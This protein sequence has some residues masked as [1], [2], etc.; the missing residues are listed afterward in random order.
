MTFHRSGDPLPSRRVHE[1]HAHVA[2]AEFGERPNPSR[3]H[4][5]PVGGAGG[6]RHV[7]H[8]EA[9]RGVV[10]VEGQLVVGAQ[11]GVEIGE[12]GHVELRQLGGRRLVDPRPPEAPALGHRVVDEHDLAVD[13]ETGVGLKSRAGRAEC[14]AGTAAACS[15]VRPLCRPGG[16]R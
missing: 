5:Q 14:R 4:P 15:R 7:E 2:L 8:R 11:L 6:G 9:G 10:Q 13:G 12:P 16:R 1:V 3:T